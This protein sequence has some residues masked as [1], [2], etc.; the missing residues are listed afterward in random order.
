MSRLYKNPDF[1]NKPIHNADNLVNALLDLIKVTLVVS[2]DLLQPLAF[3]NAVHTVSSYIQRPD[4]SIQHLIDALQQ[5]PVRA[6]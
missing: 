1:I 5:V 3:G 2:F 4:H 6:A